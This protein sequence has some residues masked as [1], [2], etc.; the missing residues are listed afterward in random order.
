MTND[1]ILNVGFPGCV[2]V[3][4]WC[5]CCNSILIENLS[6]QMSIPSGALKFLGSETQHFLFGLQCQFVVTFSR[7]LTI[8][9]LIHV[10][11]CVFVC[12]LPLILQGRLHW[13]DATVLQAGKFL[14]ISSCLQVHT[15]FTHIHTHIHTTY[16]AGKHK[17]V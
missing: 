14:H 5:H 17:L 16:C 2:I 12:F 9:A 7:E 11:L 3:L 6:E 4:L 8:R 1:K 15:L 13:T 10:C